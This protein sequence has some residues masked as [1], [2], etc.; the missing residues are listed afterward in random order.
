MKLLLPD[1]MVLP[2][3]KS[4]AVTFTE[5]VLVKINLTTAVTTA[6]VLQYMQNKMH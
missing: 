3:V 2:E 6:T 1:T 5:N 4:T